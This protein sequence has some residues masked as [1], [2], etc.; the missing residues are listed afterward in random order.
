MKEEKYKH[1]KK[2]FHKLNMNTD[3]VGRQGDRGEHETGATIFLYTVN[4]NILRT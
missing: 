1:P 4:D 3:Q 2:K